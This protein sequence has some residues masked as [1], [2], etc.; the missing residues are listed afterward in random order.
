MVTPVSI[1]HLCGRAIYLWGL[2]LGGS[3]VRVCVTS[4][5]WVAG[6]LACIAQ[7]LA[8][9]FVWVCDRPT[10]GAYVYQFGCWSH[11]DNG[12]EGV[13]EG[14]LEGFFLEF[15]ISKEVKRL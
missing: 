3:P 14:L 4:P 15:E 7:C 9:E 8:M 1:T 5:G 6:S 10:Q 13:L 11:G 12:R 2:H